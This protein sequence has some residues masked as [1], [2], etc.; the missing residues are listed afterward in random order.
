[1]K[2]KPL[3]GLER[4]RE[5]LDYNPLTGVF[6]WKMD[7]GLRVKAGDIAGRVMRNG[8]CQVTIDG[9][10]CLGHRLAWLHYNGIEPKDQIDHINMIK[11]DNSINN[12]RN[13]T[14]FQNM[15]NV[16]TSKRNKSGFKGVCFHRRDKVWQASIG[17][18][19]KLH[20]IGSFITADQ[21]SA[22]Y[23]AKAKE[24]FGEFYR[25]TTT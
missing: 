4:I 10:Q 17:F 21:V 19:G 3:P 18:N 8:Y 20:H 23:N 5:L 14:H 22:A 6:I 15:Q 1:M 16:S 24:L 25:D 9:K 2:H 7:R 12:L 11:L 13:A